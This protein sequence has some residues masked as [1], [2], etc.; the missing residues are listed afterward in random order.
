MISYQKEND[1][2]L[3]S[4]LMR[5]LSGANNSIPSI[6]LILSPECDQAC[7]YCY[8]HR[9]GHQLYPSSVFENGESILRNTEIFLDFLIENE[10]QG[11]L[12]LFS[13]EIFSQEIG[14][15]VLDLVHQKMIECPTLFQYVDIPTNYSFILDDE[16]TRRVEDIVEKFIDTSKRVYLSI[17]DDGKFMECNRPYKSKNQS[18][19]DEYYEKLMAFA[20]KYNYSFHAMVHHNNIEEWPDNWDWF[21]EMLGDH[22]EKFKLNMLE[23]RNDGWT[24]ESIAHYINF[25]KHMIDKKMEYFDYDAKRY[26]DNLVNGPEDITALILRNANKRYDDAISCSIQKS[27][28]V[29]MADLTVVPCH[30]LM[31]PEFIAGRFILDEN[32]EKIIDIEGEFVTQYLSI[33]SLPAAFQLKCYSCPIKSFCTKGCL[34][35]NY[36]TNKEVFMPVESVCKLYQS[37]FKFLYEYYD[38]LGILDALIKNKGDTYRD[39]LINAYLDLGEV[40]C[41]CQ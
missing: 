20:R 21:I 38:E 37:K 39:Y 36:E 34:G 27:I 41:E 1:L 22:G 25:L 4:Y 13:G 33:K 12:S 3:K 15:Q 29:R 6:E 10:Y 11:R 2:L 23:V 32:Q 5:G 17:S 8:M 30:R 14:F 19:G 18:R 16:K 28:A 26:V 9:Y 24:E 40:G 35:S 31:Y 7:T